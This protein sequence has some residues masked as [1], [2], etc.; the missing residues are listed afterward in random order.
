MTDICNLSD[1]FVKPES[2]H[3]LYQYVDYLTTTLRNNRQSRFDRIIASL[4]KQELCE[5]AVKFQELEST[6]A[7]FANPGLPS[8]WHVDMLLQ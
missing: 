5:L 3:D 4:P 8:V 7:Q 2:A 6:A 1:N